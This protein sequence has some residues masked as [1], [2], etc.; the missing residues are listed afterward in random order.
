M[1]TFPLRFAGLLLLIALMGCGAKLP[2]PLTEVTGQLL[3]KG[4]PLPYAYIEFYHELPDFGSEWNSS[5]VTDGKGR[6]QLVCHFQQQSG[7]LVGTHRII[8][9]EGPPPAG[10]RGMDAQSQQRLAEHMDKL[11]NRR[12]PEHFGNFSQTPLRTKVTAEQKEYVIDM[13]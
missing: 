13:K 11:G 10:A 8:V 2:P 3:Y 5:A 4:A 7:A 9:K 1:T 6:F 12:L